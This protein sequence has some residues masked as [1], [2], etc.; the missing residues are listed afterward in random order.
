M[1]ACGIKRSFSGTPAAKHGRRKAFH[2]FCFTPICPVSALMQSGKTR[3]GKEA[4]KN[5]W[6]EKWCAIQGSNL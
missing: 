4:A 3:D 6:K 5:G 1:I 2:G